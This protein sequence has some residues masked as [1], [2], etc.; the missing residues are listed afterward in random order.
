MLFS[1]YLDFSPYTP[2]F[3]PLSDQRASMPLPALLGSDPR[4]IVQ[5]CEIVPA[6][7]AAAT[8]LVLTVLPTPLLARI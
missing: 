1:H 6:V 8:A 2:V 5:L 7:A 3:S 4:A